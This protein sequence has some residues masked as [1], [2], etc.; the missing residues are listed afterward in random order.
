MGLQRVL[1]ERRS[2]QSEA[3]IL[4]CAAVSRAQYNPSSL[5]LSPDPSDVGLVVAAAM[6]TYI[7]GLAV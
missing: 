1:F 5:P 4:N 7:S 6:S 2:I 3:V